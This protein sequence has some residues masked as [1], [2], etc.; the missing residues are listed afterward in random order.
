MTQ[1]LKKVFDEIS[2]LPEEEQDAIAVFIRAEMESERRW[3]QAFAKSQ[4]TLALL[5]EEALAEHRAG[6]TRPLSLDAL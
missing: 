5:A 6:K 1:L 4:D 3:N 2:E